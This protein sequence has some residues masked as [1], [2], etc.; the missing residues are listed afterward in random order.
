MPKSCLRMTCLFSGYVAKTATLCGFLNPAKLR[1]FP[2]EFQLLP[3]KV[4]G[5]IQKLTAREFDQI[6][7]NCLK[8][9]Q[10]GGLEVSSY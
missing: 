5:K 10:N 1:F 4:T 6:I 9:T 8:S 3:K 2:F 7:G